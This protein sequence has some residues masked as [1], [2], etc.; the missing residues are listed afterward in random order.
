MGQSVSEYREAIQ[1]AARDAIQEPFT[2]PIQMEVKVLIGA[3]QSVRAPSGSWRKGARRHP[4]GSRDG[5]VD[6]YFKLVADA[7]HDIAYVNDSQIVKAVVSKEWC[8]DSAEGCLVSIASV[9]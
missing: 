7:L 2:G 4:V 9:Q 3:P 8:G 6:N 5:D 1:A